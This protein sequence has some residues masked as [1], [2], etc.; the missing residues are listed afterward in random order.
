MHS[1]AGLVVL[2]QLS[3]AEAELLS[4]LDVGRVEV[5]TRR[6]SETVAQS[7]SDSRAL[8]PEARRSRR[9]PT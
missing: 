5:M 4:Q 1:I 3:S 2:F 8:F 9:L 6:L 7:P